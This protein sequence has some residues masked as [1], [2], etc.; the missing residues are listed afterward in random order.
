M[1]KPYNFESLAAAVWLQILYLDDRDKL[2]SEPMKALKVQEFEIVPKGVKN[3]ELFWS[4]GFFNERG[5]VNRQKAAG[6]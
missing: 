6:Y 2:V 4:D 5:R 3:T 1:A